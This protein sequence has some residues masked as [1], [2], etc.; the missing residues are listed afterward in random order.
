MKKLRINNLE[1]FI[2]FLN[3][4][5]K[6]NKSPILN[7][8]N[9]S[10]VKSSSSFSV[11]FNE[12]PGIANP[13]A[14]EE[15]LDDEDIYYF[16]GGKSDPFGEEK[17][18]DILDDLGDYVEKELKSLAKAVSARGHKDI[19]EKII[20]VSNEMAGAMA[21]NIP[22]AGTPKKVSGWDDY[23]KVTPDGARVKKVWNEVM[24]ND[25]FA[26]FVQYYKAQKSNLGHDLSP[27]AFIA[28]IQ[29]EK[30]LLNTPEQNASH[31]NETL[32]T[33]REKMAPILNAT[34]GVPPTSNG[35]K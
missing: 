34:K 10:W 20:K 4:F 29:S 23:V 17:D 14:N 18:S 24:G 16:F 8:P 19:S 35:Q 30:K 15:F 26:D 27:E 25:N 5:R 22:P 21:G 2:L 6:T 3:K 12:V 1:D 13:D 9:T 11:G 33:V 28:H 31:K 7:N 32:K